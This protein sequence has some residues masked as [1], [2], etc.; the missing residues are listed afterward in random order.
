MTDAVRAPGARVSDAVGSETA[1]PVDRRMAVVVVN[2]NSGDDLAACVRS[3]YEAA[4][5]AEVE[6]VVVDNASED[7]SADRARAAAPGIRVIENAVN[8]GFPAAANQGMQATDAPWVFLLNPDATVVGGTLGGLA[9]WANARPRAGVIGVRTLNPDRT[10]YPSARKVPTYT[11]AVFHALLH[12]FA[13]D[14]RW[15]RAY[16]MEG[17]DRTSDRRVDWVSGSSMLLR[18]EA[19]DEVG[20]FDEAFFM[21]VE[22]LD[23]CTR[24]R[25][26]G[27]EVWFTPA[28]EVVHE[29]GTVTRGKRRMTLEHS[30][31]MYR[32]FVKHRS[33]GAL[34]ILRPAAWAILRL[35]A[36]VV[37]WRRRER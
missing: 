14:N 5:D 27:W 37:S 32:Y 2:M 28:L 13:N 19:L 30:R 7:D 3:V 11:E 16:T 31:S 6:V 22:D 12:P 23:L 34:A 18:R 9:A 1:L 36:V 4:G 20:P 15:S 26:A 10:A 35:R 24:M 33:P 8:R 17:W 29:G 21:Y 25:R